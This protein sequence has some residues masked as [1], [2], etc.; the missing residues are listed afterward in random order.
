VERLPIGRRDL[1]RLWIVLHVFRVRKDPG[2][3]RGPSGA[4][5]QKTY[6]KHFFV[7]N[8]VTIFFLGISEKEQKTEVYVIDS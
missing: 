8:V 7:K 6:G 3:E 1:H 5:S 4:T 2:V